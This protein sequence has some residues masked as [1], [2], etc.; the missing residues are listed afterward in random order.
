[1][2]GGLWKGRGARAPRSLGAA[3]LVLGASPLL[4]PHLLKP[5][6]QASVAH[7]ERGVQMWRRLHSLTMGFPEG[8]PILE[9]GA[10]VLGLKI[11]L[12]PSLKFFDSVTN[13]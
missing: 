6:S 12:A 8:S 10:R 9:S 11:F 7:G 2:C 3:E 13:F 1:M 4:G 5:P